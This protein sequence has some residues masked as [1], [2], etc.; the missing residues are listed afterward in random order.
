MDAAP[1][2]WMYEDRIDNEQQFDFYSATHKAPGA[3]PPPQ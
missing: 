2:V 1:E 3:V